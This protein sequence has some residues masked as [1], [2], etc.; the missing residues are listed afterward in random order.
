[1]MSSEFVHEVDGHGESLAI[2]SLDFESLDFLGDQ[3]VPKIL[4]INEQ[5]SKN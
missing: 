2:E 1:M 4:V 5:T 3:F